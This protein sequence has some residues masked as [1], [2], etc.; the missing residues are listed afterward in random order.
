[1]YVIVFIIYYQ[2]QQDIQLHG[3]GCTDIEKIGLEQ[4]SLINVYVR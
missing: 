3:I 1:M 2:F 4:P